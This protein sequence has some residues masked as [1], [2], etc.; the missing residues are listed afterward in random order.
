MDEL[1]FF[2]RC[3]VDQ[4]DL[5]DDDM[6]GTFCVLVYVLACSLDAIRW[7][8][9]VHEENVGMASLFVS[10]ACSAKRA[11]YFPTILCRS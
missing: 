6:I 5:L 7:M 10:S 8:V 1:I 11:L 9:F 2:L 3:L 4:V